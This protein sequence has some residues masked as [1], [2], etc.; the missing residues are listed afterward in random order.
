MI[1]GYERV[2]ARH[3]GDDDPEDAGES[4]DARLWDRAADQDS[5]G[6]GAAHRR[7]VAL[8]GTATDSGERVGG[9]GVG[10]LGDESEG[11]DLQ[12]DRGGEEEA[13]GGAA[14]IRCHGG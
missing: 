2:A 1:Y 13:G 11:S 10:R 5:V 4:A 9:G 3:A 14:H 8:S 7:R 12:A 6:R